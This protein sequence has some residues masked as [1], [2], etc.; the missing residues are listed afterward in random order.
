MRDK[1][2]FSNKFRLFVI[3]DYLSLGKYGILGFNKSY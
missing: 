3:R 1:S 2:K